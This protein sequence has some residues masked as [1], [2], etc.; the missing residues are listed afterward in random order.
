VSTT[1]RNVVT[2]VASMPLRGAAGTIG[3]DVARGVRMALEEHGGETGEFRVAVRLRNASTSHAG[4]SDL[5]VARN[6]REAA[7][8][9]RTVAYIGEVMSSR[10]ATSMPILNRAGLVQ[11]SPTNAYV[12]LTRAE[13]AL[14]DEPARYAPAG[15]VTFARIAPAGHASASAAVHWMASL[16]VQRPMFVEDDTHYAH[17]LSR[18]AGA[19]LPAAGMAPAGL[20]RTPGR[21][22]RELAAATALAVAERAPDAVVYTGVT[23]SDAAAV[24]N[25]L[26]AAVPGVPLF[27]F[28]GIAQP[29]LTR[30]LGREAR[31][32]LHLLDYSIEAEHL[33]PDGAAFAQRFRARFVHDPGRFALFGHEAMLVV[34]DAIARAGAAGADRRAVREALLAMPERDSPLGRYAFDAHGDTTLPHHGGATVTAGGAIVRDRWVDAR[35]PIAG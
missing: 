21:G 7:E 8:D 15:V 12:G 13:G 35:P 24:L 18:M 4:A 33:G 5:L 19:R 10:S 34:L 22:A 28:D 27:G 1:D 16:G 32:R 25:A 30:R 6:A 14:A 17:S 2:V 11:L 26:A 9:P 20:A 31:E 3:R 23:A 29:R